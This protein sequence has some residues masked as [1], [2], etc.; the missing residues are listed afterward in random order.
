MRKVPEDRNAPVAPVVNTAPGREIWTLTYRFITPVFGGGVQIQGHKKPYDPQTPVRVPSIRGQLRF[1][2]RAVNPQKCKTVAELAKAEAK[3][4]GRAAT[5]KEDQT[6]AGLSIAVV[7]QP[8]NPTPLRVFESMPKPVRQNGIDTGRLKWSINALEGAGTAYGTFPLR[9]PS[10]SPYPAPHDHGTLWTYDDE[11]VVRFEFLK[12]DGL[13]RNLEAALWA[14]THFGGLGARTRRGFGAI[15][16]IAGPALLSVEKGWEHWKLDNAP[17]V[18]WPHLGGMLTESV[19]VAF[20]NNPHARDCEARN[21]GGGRREQEHLL[22]EM[23]RLRQG[24]FGR[25]RAEERQPGRSFWPEA[26]GIR[27]RANKH[28]PNHIPESGAPKDL[29]PRGAFGTPII[30]HFKDGGRSPQHD[31]EDCTLN[32]S[33]KK[34][35]ASPLILR[36][37]L[38]ENGTY[39]A[40]ALRLRGAI[41]ESFELSGAVKAQ[42]LRVAVL[43]QELRDVKPL[44]GD[45][46]PITRYLNL[47]RNGQ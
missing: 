22:K 42:D 20:G 14:W 38:V 4:F 44:A 24:K 8:S 19:A 21:F 15:A 45:P 33:G 3:L 35:F 2:W 41:P 26:D 10:E 37:A 28:H 13:S 6:T 43:P 16:Q 7:R 30:F 36:P 31:P 9:D 12:H 18:E 32:P 29:F 23:R 11:W 25:N 17:G 47:L 39:V 27:R 5:T 1:W 34:R 40:R 46:D